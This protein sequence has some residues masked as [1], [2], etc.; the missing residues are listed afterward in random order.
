MNDEND[1]RSEEKFK[2]I[3]YDEITYR[4]EGRVGNLIKSDSLKIVG[5]AK[6]TVEHNE[7]DEVK[8]VLKKDENDNVKEIK[9]VCSCGQT[10]SVI[11]DYS[12]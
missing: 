5:K 4:E 2:E 10:K 12:E 8:V 3:P 11:L 1:F 6:I 9:F 7:D